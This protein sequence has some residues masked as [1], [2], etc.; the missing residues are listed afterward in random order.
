M[1]AFFSAAATKLPG[2]ILPALP[3]G[4]LLVALLFAPLAPSPAPLAWGM[5]LS[6]WINALL[7]ASMALVA[8]LA[9]RWIEQDPSYPAFADALKGSGLPWLLGLPL[10]LGAIGLVVVLLRGSRGLPWLWLPNTG[11]LAAVLVLVLPVLVPLVDRERQLPIR[12]LSRLAAEQGRSDEPLLVVGY[13]RYS[14]VFY[15]GRPVLFVTSAR[16]AM[17]SLDEA[18]RRSDSVLLFGSDAELLEFGIGPGDGTPVGR[19]DA[20]RLVRL[21]VQQLEQL[22]KP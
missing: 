13:K 1:V 19:R 21:P 17:R 8:V 7:L 18:A 14:V 10:L 12:A 6:G 22:G 9:P 3:G 15:S 11:W 2:Y 20:H 4:A 5:R 16:K